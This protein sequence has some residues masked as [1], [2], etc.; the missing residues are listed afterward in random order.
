MAEYFLL[1]QTEDFD[2]MEFNME[3]YEVQEC[4]MQR[5]QDDKSY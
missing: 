5:K 3:M 2:K 1:K 4:W